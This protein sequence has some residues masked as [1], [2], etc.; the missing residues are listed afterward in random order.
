MLVVFDVSEYTTFSVVCP[1]IKVDYAQKTGQDYFYF[2]HQSKI[3][4]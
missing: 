3:K 2:S 4:W 1:M